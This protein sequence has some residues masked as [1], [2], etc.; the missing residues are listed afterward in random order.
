MQ[1]VLKL[2]CKKVFLRIM[3]SF[4][5]NTKNYSMTEQKQIIE[6]F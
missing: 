1:T 6:D 2:I 4:F 3:G 5:F